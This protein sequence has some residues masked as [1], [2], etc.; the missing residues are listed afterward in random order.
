MT[1]ADIAVKSSP[2][3]YKKLTRLYCMNG[4]FHLQILADGTVA[5][6]A[7]ENTYSILRIKATSPG[8]VV[9]EG[10]ETGLYLS[11]NEHGKLYASSLVTDESYFLEKMEENHYNTYQSQKYGENWYVGIKKNGKMKRG[12]RTHIGQKA[13]FFLPRQVEQEED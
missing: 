9:I 7:D 13:I 3:D 8:V 5:G 10:S 2:R 12:P 1:E 11:M 4:G 6:A